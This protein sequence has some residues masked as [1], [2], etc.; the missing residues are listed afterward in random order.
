M[1]SLQGSKFNPRPVSLVEM[2]VDDADSEERLEIGGSINSSGLKRCAINPAK[3]FVPVVACDASSVKIGETETGM[4]FAIRAVGVW[5]QRSKILYTRWGP[6]LFHVPNSED[7][8]QYREDE[9]RAFGGLSLKTLRVLTRLRNHVERWTQEVLSE[10]LH[11]GILLIDGSLTAGTPDNPTARVNKILATARQ[12][13]SIVIGISKATQLTVG[14]RNILGLTN[15]KDSPHLIDISS[16]VESEYPPYPVRFLG[17][18]YEAKLS[19]DGFLFRT[20]IDRE[21]SQEQGQQALDRLPGTAVI[22]PGSRDVMTDGQLS[23]EEM[24]PLNIS[25]EV[26]ALKGTAL[27]VSKIRGTIP[28]EKALSP[29][30]SWLPSRTSSLIG[31]Y[32]I[33]RLIMNGGKRPLPVGHNDGDPVQID[34]GGLDGGLNIITGRKGTGKSHLAKLLLLSMAGLGA[35]CI[36]LDVNGEYVNLHKSKDGRLSTSRLTV[37]APRSGIHLALAKLGFR[38]MAGVLSNALDLPATSSKVFSTIWRDLE[39]KGDLTLPNLIQAVQSWNCHESVREALTSRLQVLLESGIFY[40]EANPLTEEKILHAIDGGGILVVNLKNQSHTVRRIIVEIFLGEL[41]KILSSNWLRAAFLFAEEAH[42]YLRDTYWDDIITRMR[43]IG[44]FTTFITNQPDTVQETI[45]RQA[46]N[47]FIFNFTNEHDIETIGK[48]AK[49]DSETIRSL[50]RGTPA[51][52]CLLLGNVVHD[53]PLMVDIEALD[54]RTMGE[55]RL[56]FS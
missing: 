46:D 31:A 38:T 22:F 45:Y 41:T 29:T 37:I 26:D 30:P 27:A 51:R 13:N 14:G 53:L 35:P 12:N 2:G 11:G 48:V 25:S 10:S 4:I 3:D 36:V 44:L 16:L 17:R 20:D 18:V 8:S 28:G 21:P 34:A 5:R 19:S 40:D 49:S 55:T 24:E 23:G 7:V 1:Q 50:I 47:V 43:H 39:S 52:R 54:V 6:L 15:D 32:P 56:F 42:L 9:S 33:N